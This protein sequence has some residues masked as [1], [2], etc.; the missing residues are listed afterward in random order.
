MVHSP[1]IREKYDN[2]VK[3]TIQSR[4]FKFVYLFM[5][6][7]IFLKRRLIFLWSFCASG[8]LIRQ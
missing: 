7:K 3:K 4:I 6:N 2:T 8:S 5:E 1:H